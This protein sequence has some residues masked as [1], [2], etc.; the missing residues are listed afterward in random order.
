MKINGWVIT[1]F[2]LT[3][4]GILIKRSANVGSKRILDR[5]IAQHSKHFHSI[6]GATESAFFTILQSIL[7]WK[8]NHWFELVLHFVSVSLDTQ[9]GDII[10]SD[11]EE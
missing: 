7:C 10:I 11:H 9:I 4:F 3:A 1:R 8:P 6:L 2:N 5:F